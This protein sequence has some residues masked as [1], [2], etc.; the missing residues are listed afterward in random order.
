MYGMR[1]TFDVTKNGNLVVSPPHALEAERAYAAVSGVDPDREPIAAILR[2]WRA[3]QKQQ[4]PSFQ[5]PYGIDG[6]TLPPPLLEAL[7]PALVRR[8]MRQ[9][10]RAAMSDAY[11]IG[12]WQSDPDPLV[13]K[14]LSTASYAQRTDMGT[15]TRERLR[16]QTLRVAP[17]V[18]AQ[19][20]YLL[21]YTANVQGGGGKAGMTLSVFRFP[22]SFS[23]L[24]R[25]AREHRTHIAYNILIENVSKPGTE[26][27]YVHRIRLDIIVPY[28]WYRTVY[29]RGL[30][31]I[32]GHLV[33]DVVG[34]TDAGLEVVAARQGGTLALIPSFAT[35]RRGQLH[36]RDPFP[37][38]R[39][40]NVSRTFLFT[41]LGMR[42]WAEGRDPK[43]NEYRDGSEY[44][45]RYGEKVPQL[46][47]TAPADE[48]SRW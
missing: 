33:L 6:I 12:V 45:L 29:K 7:R 37:R 38:V 22:V 1:V 42:Y 3:A 25:E 4:D 44:L 34:P 20:G 15:W 10:A 41:P 19:L 40:P 27:R 47:R 8:Q 28:A 14:M 31:V 48:S 17:A 9:K 11:G 5:A 43:T 23:A 39:M 24:D 26:A 16:C 2:T 21:P 46:V 13:G 36:W 35:I 30:A 18:L 32:D